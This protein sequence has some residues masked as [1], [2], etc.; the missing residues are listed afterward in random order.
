[1]K[2]VLHV[3]TTIERG[4]A[5][6]QLL[7]LVRSQVA[8]GREVF[9]LPLK[10]NL[11]LQSEFVTSGARVGGVLHNQHFVFQIFRLTKF[12]LRTPYLI[13]A[14]LPRAEILVA[15]IPL[16]IDFVF[17]RHNAE[18]FFPGG[19][20]RLSKYLSRFVAVRAKSGIA[21]SNAVKNYL[22]VVGEIKYDYNLHVVHY[23]LDTEFNDDSTP[24]SVR[25]NSLKLRIGTVGRLVPQKDYKTLLQAFHLY[26][27]QDPE[28]SLTII[29]DGA[30]RASLMENAESLSMSDKVNWVGKT[31][32]I[33]NFMKKFDVFILTSIYEGFGL[34]LLEAMQSKIPIIA[35][36]NSA[37]PE[38]IGADHIGLC[39]TGNY[40]DFAAKIGLFADPSIRRQVV[41]K[42]SKQLLLFNPDLMRSKIDEIYAD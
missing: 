37:I 14:H 15:L 18:A 20:R 10:G 36:N 41:E 17:S 1:M 38:V 11:D 8:S 13:H 3:I 30:L 34:V 2:P 4:G 21:I 12:L 7:T 42:Q 6:N 26:S 24:V 28:A 32:G 40:L 33:Y 9:V 31:S 27:L 25:E 35:S 22:N 5:E 23:G 39:E 19:G 29:G 16:R